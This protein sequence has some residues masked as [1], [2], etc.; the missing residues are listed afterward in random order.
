MTNAQQAPSWC[1]RQAAPS[2][3]LQIARIVAQATNCGS[4]YATSA[5]QPIVTKV[6]PIDEKRLARAQASAPLD[7]IGRAS[8][9][10]GASRT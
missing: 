6:D 8:S 1:W 4:K 9:G 2:L 10:S 7:S 5:T 3:A